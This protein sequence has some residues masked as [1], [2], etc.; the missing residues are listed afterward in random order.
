VSQF[1][2][3]PRIITRCTVKKILKM[4]QSGKPQKTVK[5]GAGVLGGG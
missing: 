3:L 2:Y 5:Y 4:V 1:G